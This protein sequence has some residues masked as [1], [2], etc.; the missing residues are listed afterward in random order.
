MTPVNPEPE[1]RPRDFVGA[2]VHVMNVL[3]AFDAEH[4]QM[5]LSE[6]SKQTGLDRAGARRYLLSLAHLGYVAQEGKVFRLTPKVL[7]LGYAFMATMPLSEIAQSYLNKVCERTGET[8]A[9]AI[10]DG[11]H[12]VHIARANTNRLFAPVIHVG[13]RFPALNT[14][15]GRVMVAYKADTELDE[16]VKK[17]ELNRASPWGVTTKT[18]LRNELLKIRKQ[19]Y[20]IADQEIEEGVRSIAAPVFNGEGKA[21]AALIVVTNVA[22]VPKKKLVDEFLPVLQATA[23]EMRGALRHA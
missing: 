6:V 10:L 3:K 9:I 8:A 13:G 17:A 4:P 22:T 1:Q 2:V 5:T 19:G 18:Q 16:F 15:T 23:Q 12:I 11:D 21:L 20:A 7:E 14:S